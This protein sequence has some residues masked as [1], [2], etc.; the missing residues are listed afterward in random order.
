MVISWHRV[1]DGGEYTVRLWDV[2][3]QTEVATLEGHTSWVRSV[4]FSS[5]GALLA[6]ASQD[7]TVKL[8]DVVGREEIATLEGHTAE[9]TS[10]AF[11]PGGALLASGGGWGEYTV[12][13]WDVATQTEVATLEGHGAEV[14]SVSFSPDG[15]LLASGSREWD[16]TIRL[17]NV[18]TGEILAVFSGHTDGVTSVSFSP[19]STTLASG[20]WDRTIKLWNVF[21]WTGSR[22]HTV[23]KISGDEQQGSANTQ[24]AEPLVV[25]VLDED[26]EAV[27]GAVVTFSV[28]AGEGMLSSTIATT[29]A[30]PCTI[31][32]STSLTFATTDANGQ[33]AT[34]LTL[35]SKLGT[36]TVE[37]TVEGLEPETFTATRRRASN[38]P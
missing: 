2:A 32:S 25:S 19:D 35:G 10:V 30:N 13:L 7:S 11:S 8:W 21:Q 27:A 22:P 33:A 14:T 6:S 9:V 38:A 31:E 29:D 37:A 4:A 34:R 3:I 17:W 26:G 5:D 23:V 16:D 24:L 15:A 12:R 1:G 28:T 36:N 18:S 20:S